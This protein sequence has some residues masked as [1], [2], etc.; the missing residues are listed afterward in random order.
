MTNKLKPILYALVATSAYIASAYA[1]PPLGD[2]SVNSPQGQLLR[3]IMIA[4]GYRCQTLRYAAYLGTGRR[5]MLFRLVCDNYE[6]ELERTANDFVI[7][8]K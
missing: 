6:Y 8:E 2:L 7:T 5:G 3:K 4:K 1:E